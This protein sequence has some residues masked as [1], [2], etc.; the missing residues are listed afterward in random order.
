LITTP[1]PLFVVHDAQE[2]SVL[3][4]T[5]GDGHDAVI[6]AIVAG[7]A[8]QARRVMDEHIRTRMAGDSRRDRR[9]TPS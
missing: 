7:D 2:H 4:E 8:E 6:E 5:S 1:T 9:R 3:Q